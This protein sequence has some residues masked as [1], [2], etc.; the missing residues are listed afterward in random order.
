MSYSWTYQ[1]AVFV[2]YNSYDAEYERFS[3]TVYDDR[4]EAKLICEILIQD[5]DVFDAVVFWRKQSDWEQS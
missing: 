4:R 1:Y 3:S 2:Q 5:P